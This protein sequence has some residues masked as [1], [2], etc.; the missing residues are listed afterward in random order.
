VIND[1]E[2][3]VMRHALGLTRSSREYRNHLVTGEGST[4]YPICESLVADGLMRRYDGNPLSG[5]DY[6]YKVTD[7]GRKALKQ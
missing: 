3:E 7:A 4:D 2:R 6:I 5:G 1:Q